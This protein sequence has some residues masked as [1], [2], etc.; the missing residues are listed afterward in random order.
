MWEV[1]GTSNKAVVKAQAGF[2]YGVDGGAA[3]R[4]VPQ[5]G[6]LQLQNWS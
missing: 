1:C 6:D 5:V 4:T 2:T 3:Q